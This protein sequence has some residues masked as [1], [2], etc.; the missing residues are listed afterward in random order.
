MNIIKKQPK[1]IYI[2]LAI[3]LF[4]TGFI[5]FNSTQDKPTSKERSERVMEA[6][7]PYIAHIIGSDNYNINTVRKAAHC[8]EY[9]TLSILVSITLLLA[10]INCSKLKKFFI[11]MIYCLLI[12]SID[13]TIQLFSNRGAQISDVLLDFTASLIAALILSLIC[14]ITKKIKEKGTK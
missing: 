4:F 6:A 5:W 11:T 10:K 1:Y 13:E 9:F 3:C 12:A 7:R 14:F 8:I 2:L